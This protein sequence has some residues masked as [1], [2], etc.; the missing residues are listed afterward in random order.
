VT[1]V[2]GLIGLAGFLLAGCST[3]PPAPS[4]AGTSLQGLEARSLHLPSI[5]PGVQG[6]P[7]T[8]GRAAA[9]LG[10]FDSGAVAV[11]PGPVYA[12]TYGPSPAAAA[13][14]F[15]PVGNGWHYAKVPFFS[16]PGYQGPVVIRGARIDGTDPV[17]FDGH[18]NQVSSLEL[19]PADAVFHPGGG[20]RGGAA[21]VLVRARGCYALQVDGSGF[22][23]VVVFLALV[24]MPTSPLAHPVPGGCGSTTVYEG[25]P[26]QWLVDAAG[27]A[28]APSTLPYLSSASGLIGG[29]IFGYPLRAGRHGDPANKI[30]W[31]VATARNGSPLDIEG[32][33]QGTTS[34]AVTYGFPDNASPGEIYPSIVDVPLPGCWSFTLSWGS[35]EAQVQLAFVA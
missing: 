19:T 33:R 10:P 32:H 28:D 18:P 30:L 3:A 9:T 21:G 20:W 4:A 17:R 11:G 34:P 29:F 2:A 22:S 5:N 35:G 26:P 16:R 24:D 27:G 6:C 14:P 7:A 23:V 31:A 13:L 25:G 8:V 12:L 1:R 15:S